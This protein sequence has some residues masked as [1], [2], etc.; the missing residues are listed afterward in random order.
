MLWT[1]IVLSAGCITVTTPDGKPLWSMVGE[2]K[3]EPE[4][5]VVKEA[6]KPPP[7]VFE[8]QVNDTSAAQV[9]DALRAE[10]DYAEAHPSG[11]QPTTTEVTPDAAPPKA[12]R[13][14]VK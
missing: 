11:E 4:K 5:P 9:A 8:D 12:R 1:P 10:L 14:P 2:K 13:Y 6:P 3:P 7:L